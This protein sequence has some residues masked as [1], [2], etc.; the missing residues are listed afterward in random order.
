MQSSL[1]VDFLLKTTRG[2]PM[3]L[4]RGNVWGIKPA[5]SAVSFG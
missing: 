4:G 3:S 5:N 1:S 2:M